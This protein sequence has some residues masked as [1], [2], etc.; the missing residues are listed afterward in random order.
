MIFVAYPF[1]ICW[2]LDKVSFS[3]S[4]LRIDNNI[5]IPSL[6]NISI[7]NS[8][9]SSSN[10]ENYNNSNE[11]SGLNMLSPISQNSNERNNSIDINFTIN[12]Y[13]PFSSNNT[14]NIGMI[15]NEEILNDN[16]LLDGLYGEHQ[17]DIVYMD[18]VNYIKN[19]NFKFDFRQ[20][21][22]SVNYILESNSIFIITSFGEIYE[23][24]L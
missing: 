16:Y 1:V 19:I 24:K 21:I 7:I 18:N 2:H 15:E 23:I 13:S 6:S 5:S 4:S 9:N 17:I 10:K 11:I 12:L 20:Q 3:K 22:E 8:N 14:N